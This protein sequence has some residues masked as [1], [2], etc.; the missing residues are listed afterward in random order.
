MPRLAL[1]VLVAALAAC[2]SRPQPKLDAPQ[3]IALAH[4][5]GHEGA[6][7]QA[8]D[9]PRLRARAIALVNA[10]KVPSRLEEPLM[11][12]VGALQAPVCVPPVPAAAPAPA[13]APTPAPRPRPHGH[14]HDHRPDHHGHGPGHG[15]GD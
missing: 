11:S 8:R 10:G 14:G 1:L 13:P 3:L 4:R 6:C 9:V 5:I 7:A 2:G 15:K 12:G